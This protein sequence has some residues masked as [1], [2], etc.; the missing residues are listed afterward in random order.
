MRRVR[1]L[2]E[3]LEA[4]RTLLKHGAD[5]QFAA[6][7]FDE[8]GQSADIQVGAPFDLRDAGLFGAQFRRAGMSQWF[9]PDPDLLF[10]YGC[11]APTVSSRR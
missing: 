7:S 1:R 3:S 8:S 6:H 10:E 5:L 9:N 11:E 4:D 2:P